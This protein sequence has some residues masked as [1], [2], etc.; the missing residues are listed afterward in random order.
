MMVTTTLWGQWDVVMTLVQV[1]VTVTVTV[2]VTCL[3]HRFKQWRNG[4]TP[5][6]PLCHVHWRGDVGSRLI[7][8]MVSGNHQTVVLDHRHLQGGHLLQDRQDR[9]YPVQVHRCCRGQALATMWAPSALP[10][11]QCHLKY[12]LRVRLPHQH[13]WSRLRWKWR[14][15]IVFVAKLLVSAGFACGSFDHRG[16]HTWMMCSV[17]LTIRPQPAPDATSNDVRNKHTREDDKKVFYRFCWVVVIRI[18]MAWFLSFQEISSRS[19][20]HDHHDLIV[21]RF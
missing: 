10:R 8:G 4:L 14:Q 21:Q 1:V 15:N 7:L 5:M 18:C 6:R 3:L 19:I 13:H 20:H 16:L 2:T 9:R 11:C 17:W 12:P